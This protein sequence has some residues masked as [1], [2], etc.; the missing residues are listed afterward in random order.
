MPKLPTAPVTDTYY[1]NGK[2]LLR[3]DEVSG[4]QVLCEDVG[5]P[6]VIVRLHMGDLAA[7]R[8]VEVPPSDDSD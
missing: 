7:M 8:R 6:D 5:D 2:R 1:T 4:D 3:V